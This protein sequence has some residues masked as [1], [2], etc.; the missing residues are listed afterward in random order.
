MLGNQTVFVAFKIRGGGS[1]GNIVFQETHSSTQTNEFG[2]FNLQIGAGSPVFGSMTAIN[3]STGNYW[4]EIDIDAGSGLETIGA[5]RLIS[6][7]YALHANTVTNADDADADPTNEL[8]EEFTFTDD[9]Q[10]LSITD[11]GGTKSVS[12]AGIANYSDTIPTNELVT[13]FVFNESNS[14]LTLSQA[15]GDLGVNLSALINDADADSTNEKISGIFYNSAS[16]SITITEGGENY[17][18]G[19]GPFD[20]DT[21]PTNELIDL[22][23][24]S[25]SEEGILTIEEAGVLH[26]VDLSP[27]N[28]TYWN[29]SIVTGAVFNITERIGI[30]ATNPSARLEVRAPITPSEPA[31]RVYTSAGAPALEVNNN[32]VSTSPSSAM[33]INGKLILGTKILTS[34]TG[35]YNVLPED[36]VIVVK[37]LASG[38]SSISINLP[39]AETNIGRILMIKSVGPATTFQSVTVSGQGNFI[40]FVDP[41]ISL[42]AAFNGSIT[43]VSIGA[44]GWIKL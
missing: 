3:W 12:L 37:R 10:I 15:D 13:D 31:L 41:S 32:V 36:V 8:I 35:F 9:S 19:L 5:M 38:A 39:D 26:E 18:T 34:A 14:Q 23:G 40:D 33:H 30:G 27:L 16:N 4:L 2:L 20:N 11:P 29:K 44:D 24:L 6:V 17:S 1:S 28:I 22:N 43:L 21:D 42:S 7:P 25:L